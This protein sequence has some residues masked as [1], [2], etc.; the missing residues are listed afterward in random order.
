MVSSENRNKIV[1]KNIISADSIKKTLSEGRYFE[2]PIEEDDKHVWLTDSLVIYEV[3]EDKVVTDRPNIPTKPGL[4]RIVNLGIMFSPFWVLQQESYS[5][6]T[7][8]FGDIP[9]VAKLN[10]IVTSFINNES[11]YVD[12]GLFPKIGIMLY[13]PPGNGKTASIMELSKG[14]VSDTV[15]VMAEGTSDV[16]DGLKE[17]LPL[18]SLTDGAKRIMVILEDIGGAGTAHENTLD[19]SVF[20]ELL[21]N[22]KG[23]VKNPIIYIMTTN[24]PEL[25]KENVINRPGRVDYVI[26]YSEIPLESKQKFL[27]FLGA[28]EE[29]VLNTEVC[30]YLE[31]DSFTISHV[32]EAYIRHLVRKIP[33]IDALKEVKDQIDL[34]NDNFEESGKIGI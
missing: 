12:S 10:Q 11:V 26:K 18:I 33:L 31:F 29:D 27:R 8:F 14:L 21:D 16:F 5:T 15:V 20:L 22:S 9:A 34:F 32:K 23:L 13:G 17:I 30:S 25:I 28:T 2:W 19:N 1:V 6:K 24:Y 4:Y 7:P 3:E